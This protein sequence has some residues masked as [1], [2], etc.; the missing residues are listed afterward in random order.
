MAR[1][2]HGRLDQE[3][4]DIFHRFEPLDKGADK[5]SAQFHDLGGISGVHSIPLEDIEAQTFGKTEQQEVFKS[6]VGEG[7]GPRGLE[8]YKTFKQNAKYNKYVGGPAKTSTNGIGKTEEGG[9]DKNSKAILANDDLGEV[10]EWVGRTLK[11]VDPSKKN[12]PSGEAGTN[13]FEEKDEDRDS[14]DERYQMQKH[15]AEDDEFDF[16]TL[17]KKS[18]S[19]AVGYQASSIVKNSEDIAREE[20]LRKKIQKKLEGTGPSLKGG[21]GAGMLNNRLANKQKELEKKIDNNIDH[22][23]TIFQSKTGSLTFSEKVEDKAL[24]MKPATQIISP[25]LIKSKPELQIV[26]KKQTTA[27]VAGPQSIVEEDEWDRVNIQNKQALQSSIS[28]SKLS[29]TDREKQ[30]AMNMGHCLANTTVCRLH[31]GKTANHCGRTQKHVKKAV[32]LL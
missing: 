20:E 11:R 30:S 5:G 23:T 14:E 8:Q 7:D 26:A 28:P 24:L 21:A 15:K 25:S 22:T 31:F 10:G 12:Q 3:E 2:L 29:V 1:Q 17:P 18:A 9:I 19:P 32:L 6:K 4:E 13:D 16:D 27:L